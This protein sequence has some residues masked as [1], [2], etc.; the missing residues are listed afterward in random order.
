MFS[1]ILL[2]EQLAAFIPLGE[3]S[4]NTSLALLGR[5][6]PACVLSLVSTSMEET[7]L[8][9]MIPPTARTA[10]IAIATKV[11]DHLDPIAIEAMTPAVLV[12]P[13][14]QILPSPLQVTLTIPGAT[15]PAT[16]AI[17]MTQLIA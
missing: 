13:V 1:R 15:P 5:M 3:S 6:L 8:L 10:G 4:K 16:A 12:V 2:S 14:H 17:P 9:T 7:V 11:G